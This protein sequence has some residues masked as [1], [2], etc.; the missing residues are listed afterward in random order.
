LEEL[1]QHAESQGVDT[2]EAVKA[3]N[4]MRRPI[5][6]PVSWGLSETYWKKAQ[7]AILTF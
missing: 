1:I 7:V 6:T 5:C 4:M 3:I 2:A